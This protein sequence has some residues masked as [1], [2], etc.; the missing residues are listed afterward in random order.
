MRHGAP[1]PCCKGMCMNGGAMRPSISFSGLPWVIQLCL[2]KCGCWWLVRLCM[3]LAGMQ[4]C[5]YVGVCFHRSLC[6]HMYTREMH[7]QCQFTDVKIYM[8]ERESICIYDSVCAALL[9]MGLT[10]LSLDL[11]L[12]CEESYWY[13][14]D[15]YAP[16]GDQTTTIFTMNSGQNAKPKIIFSNAEKDSLCFAAW[17]S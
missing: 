2:G 14:L 1:G 10:N 9:R 8:Q 12:V 6:L 5:M 17:F 13:Q 3:C 11:A 15:L 7:P 16:R 4:A